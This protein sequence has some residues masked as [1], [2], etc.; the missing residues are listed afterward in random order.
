VFRKIDRWGSIETTALHA[1][2]LPKLLARRWALAGIKHA[3]R[4]RLSRHG[5]RVGFITEAYK[6]GARDKSYFGRNRTFRVL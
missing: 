1:Y 2:A 3:G 4:E 5:L 6:A